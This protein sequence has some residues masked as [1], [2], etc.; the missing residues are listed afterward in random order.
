[1]LARL[2]FL[3]PNTA[4]QGEWLNIDFDA[5]LFHGYYDS[6]SAWHLRTRL[7]LSS[8][9]EFSAWVQ[10]AG[11]YVGYRLSIGN[12]PAVL[13]CF[14]INST[15]G[16]L[17]TACNTLDYVLQPTWVVLVDAVSY[18]AGILTD[19]ARVFVNLIFVQQPPFLLSPPLSDSQNNLINSLT[20]S[21]NA[22]VGTVIGTVRGFD[23]DAPITY[24]I[25]GSTS[26]CTI[27]PHPAFSVGF[28]TG[29]LS[30]ATAGVLD[31]EDC[32]SFTLLLNLSD[33]VSV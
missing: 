24:T 22:T 25:V 23:R 3:Y 1:M 12:P 27:P 26:L 10:D 8:P 18:P 29:I 6:L 7:I 19:T 2:T 33:T 4:L 14:T 17:S 13:S 9:S 20:I 31:W 5:A 30:I 15:T 32:V 16:A 21:E 11:A 28:R